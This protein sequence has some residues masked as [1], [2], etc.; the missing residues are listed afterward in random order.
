VMA[1]S[2]E[3]LTRLINIDNGGGARFSGIMRSGPRFAFVAPKLVQPSRS[4]RPDK[5]Y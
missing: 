1:A 5:V 2:T 4:L 3:K